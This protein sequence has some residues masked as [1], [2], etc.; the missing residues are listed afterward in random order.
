M[1]AK[2]SP[3][4]KAYLPLQRAYDYFN[5]ELFR[6]ELPPC[7]IVLRKSGRAYG[8]YHAK[9]WGTRKGQSG[10]YDEI[11]LCPTSFLNRTDPEIFST[12]V[13]EM[14]HCWQ[15]RF[16]S[17]SRGKYHNREF[18]Q[19]M[20]DLGLYP[21]DTGKPGGAETGQNMSHYI[22][23]GCKFDM[24]QKKLGEKIEF[25]RKDVVAASK[26][27]NKVK[28]ECEEC[29]AKAWGKPS[30]HIICGECNSKMEPAL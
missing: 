6:G 12:L 29:D 26:P 17:P 20:K 28:F 22:M 7:L 18:A 16:G 8:Y 15:E 19:K 13:H 11:C 3:S 10:E 1:T 4:E 21:S 5:K 27:N 9:Q 30:L 23:P 25:V 14:V 24:S 2:L